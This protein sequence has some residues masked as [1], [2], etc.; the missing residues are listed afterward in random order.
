MTNVI[1]PE[2]KQRHNEILAEYW[3]AQAEVDAKFSRLLDDLAEQEGERILALKGH[4]FKVGDRVIHGHGC[5]NAL[6]AEVT[7][8]SVVVTL[9]IND[10]YYADRNGPGQYAEI[11]GPDDEN[12]DG[13]YLREREGVFVRYTIQPD[14]SPVKKN[15]RSPKECYE[16]S[17]T[18]E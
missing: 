9:G 8:V 3:K 16:A 15:V 18:A 2:F 6:P 1:S 13:D 12:W 14:P 11:L 7:K 10:D 4:K 17:L 5:K